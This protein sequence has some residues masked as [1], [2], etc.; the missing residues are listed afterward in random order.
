MGKLTIGVLVIVF[1]ISGS[2]HAETFIENFSTTTNKDAGNTTANWDTATGLLKLPGSGATSEKPLSTN[3]FPT[4]SLAAVYEIG[5]RFIPQVNGQITALGRYDDA[6]HNNTIITLWNDSGGQ[7][8]QVTVVN[9]AGWSW[10]ALGTPVNV[11]A[12]TAYRVSLWCS[13]GYKYGAWAQPQIR[14]NIQIT[15]YCYLVNTHAYPNLTGT[16]YMYG[17]PDIEFTVGGGYQTPK[18]GQSTKINTTFDTIQAVNLSVSGTLPANTAIT[19]EITANAGTNWYQI[20]PTAQGNEF[21][22]PQVGR[23][24]DLRWRANLSTANTNVTPSLDQLIIT[25]Y[26]GSALVTTTNWTGLVNTNPI[27]MGQSIAYIKFDAKTDSGT[28]CWKRFRVDK[29]LKTYTNSAC[30]DNKIEVQVWCDTNTNGFWD[31]GDTFIAKGNFT[32]GTCYLNMNRWQVTT[33]SK[34]YYIV[35]KLANDI[36]GGQRAGVSVKDSSYLEFENATCVGVP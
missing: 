34:T 16:G 27:K 5:W 24:N 32:N 18:T 14:G 33:T 28:A 6:S 31:T 10:A 20:T 25:Y 21:I 11:T 1:I 9:S 12:G 13:T 2:L 3:T 15:S 22:I 4:S 19:Y 26:T 23:G 7:L 36:G 8:A 35:Y 30:P 29:G 17:V